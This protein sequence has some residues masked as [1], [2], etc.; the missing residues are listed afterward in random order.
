MREEEE[1]AV[2]GTELSKRIRRRRRIEGKR[3][4]DRRRKMGWTKRI[5]RRR[6]R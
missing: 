5:E 6:G 2:G 1:E 3:W 4:I